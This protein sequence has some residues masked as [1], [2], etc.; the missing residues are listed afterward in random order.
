[1]SDHSPRKNKT[2]LY[3]TSAMFSFN[4]VFLIYDFY[5]ESM[6]IQG[7][8]K[9]A[10]NGAKLTD[11]VIKAI[12]YNSLCGLHFLHSS[13]IFLRKITKHNLL[14][15]SS[16]EIKYSNFF[17]ARSPEINEAYKIRSYLNNIKSLNSK[18]KEDVANAQR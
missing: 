16:C 13:N 8:M 5:E 1:M 3:D 12:V 15:N 14:V 9:S 17:M 2:R 11:E 6:N 18:N 4:S 7:L 10:A